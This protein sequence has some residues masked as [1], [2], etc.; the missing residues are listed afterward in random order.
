MHPNHPSL[1]RSAR[2][3]PEG[4]V[5]VPEPISDN[6]EFCL[7][8]KLADLTSVR[9]FQEALDAVGDAQAEVNEVRA[10]VGYLRSQVQAEMRRVERDLRAE[11][12]K[13]K[14]T[15]LERML[16]TQDRHIA[17]EA[18]LAQL[19]SLLDY[20]TQALTLLES[21]AFSLRVAWKDKHGG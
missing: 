13:T 9:Q 16:K 15:E 7:R 2:L 5:E 8:L 10:Q 3:L 11:N 14:P 1:Q 18:Q 17:L 21:K 4:S 12:P 20:C 19:V 6:V